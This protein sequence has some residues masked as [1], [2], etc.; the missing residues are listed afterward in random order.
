MENTNFTPK[1]SLQTTDS[2]QN[3]ERNPAKA[4]AFTS[5]FTPNLHHRHTGRRSRMISRKKEF[6]RAKAISE[7]SEKLSADCEVNFAAQKKYPGRLAFAKA[8]LEDAYKDRKQIEQQLRDAETEYEVTKQ[9]TNKANENVQQLLR[10][11]DEVSMNLSKILA[12]LEEA[13]SVIERI[14]L[15][16][17]ILRKTYQDCKFDP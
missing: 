4:H 15:K 3:E 13:T 5:S 16:W 11:K 12:L 2:K 17:E 7:R 14:N 6:S 8:K 1:S 9:N 10:Q